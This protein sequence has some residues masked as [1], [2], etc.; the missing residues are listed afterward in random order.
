MRHKYSVGQ[1]KKGDAYP[2]TTLAP[3][4]AKVTCVPCWRKEDL[5]ELKKKKK[6]KKRVYKLETGLNLWNMEVGR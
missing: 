6:V 1:C 5:I 2:W 4:P 3:S